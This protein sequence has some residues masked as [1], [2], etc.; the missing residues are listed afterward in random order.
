MVTKPS[1]SFT[2][3]AHRGASAHAPENTLLAVRTALAMNA[4]WIEVDVFAVKDA[5]LVIHD[6]RLERTTNGVGDITGK[7][8]SYLRRL[9]AG[10]GEKI[11]FLQ[12]VLEMVSKRAGINIE[13]KGPGTAIPTARLL[14]RYLSKGRIRPENLLVS[15][16]DHQAL[17]AFQ[18]IAPHIPIGA[19]IYGLPLNN[20]GVAAEL[21][22]S[23]VHLHSNFVN[24]RLVTDAHRRGL[25]V[26]VY[27]IN[28]AEDLARMISLDVDGVFTDHPELFGDPH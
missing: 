28:N 4:P 27:T 24:R 26:Y 6:R 18:G 16:F 5:L 20:A 17:A 13:L 23:S 21:R 3:F 22:L 19:N 10:K 15:S 8:I 14:S 7:D 2:W 11:P 12:E 25:R 1:P 9:D